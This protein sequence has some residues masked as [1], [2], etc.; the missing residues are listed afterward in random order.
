MI[1]QVTK[2]TVIRKN[3]SRA[4]WQAEVITT[5]CTFTSINTVI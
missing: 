3:A 5:E 1:N 4:I 2:T